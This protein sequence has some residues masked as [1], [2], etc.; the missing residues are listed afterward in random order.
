VT[1][2]THIDIPVTV[3]KTSACDREK[4]DPL[5]LATVDSCGA[6]TSACLEES[7]PIKSVGAPLNTPSLSV[8]TSNPDQG[9][10]FL[11]ATSILSPTTRRKRALAYSDSNILKKG[12]KV[13]LGVAILAFGGL[14]AAANILL[15]NHVNENFYYRMVVF[16]VATCCSC[17]ASVA[18]FSVHESENSE[19]IS[20]AY[21]AAG[22]AFISFAS[23][24]IMGFQGAPIVKDFSGQLIH[25]AYLTEHAL[26]TFFIIS[27]METVN[28]DTKR[29]LT[30]ICC[31]V[32][33][34]VSWI[35]GLLQPTMVLG[36]FISVAGLVLYA[37]IFYL[38][39][40]ALKRYRANKQKP[41]KQQDA[42]LEKAFSLINTY[43]MTQNAFLT[44][45]I[46]GIIGL[47]NWVFQSFCYS[48]LSLVTKILI[49]E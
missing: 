9:P 14:I 31:Q 30:T 34:V 3:K 19:K 18:A 25:T 29:S 49:G 5:K 36:I 17:I 43:F 41:R 48:C 38:W 20:A 46:L 40:S 23:H 22:V 24:M 4:L 13:L 7:I 39:Y 26:E 12:Y 47:Y 27:I 44:I 33:A 15:K 1:A 8:T 21:S 42:N 28:W 16:A 11:A 37:Q 10:A 6:T 45:T 32:G 35:A 2:K